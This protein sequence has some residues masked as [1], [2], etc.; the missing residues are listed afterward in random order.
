MYTTSPLAARSTANDPS[1]LN[2]IA[3]LTQRTALPHGIKHDAAIALLQN[4]DFILRLDPEFMSYTCDT[5]PAD[6]NPDTK[7]YTVTD[8]MEALPRGLWDTTVAFTAQLTNIEKGVHWRINAPLG[9]VQTSFWTVE[10]EAGAGAGAEAEPPLWLVEEV[11]IRCSRL[12][13]GTVR[14]KVEANSEG[15]HRKFVDRLVADV[16]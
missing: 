13:V 4:H 10:R 7:Y 8:H 16:A 9:L 11:E 15:I 5:A 2:T 3:T 14:A 1:V 6:A 12:L